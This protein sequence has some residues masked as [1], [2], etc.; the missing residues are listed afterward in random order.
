MT[1]AVGN[2]LTRFEIESL[3]ARRDKI[4]TLFD[5]MIAGRGVGAVL[6]SFTP[7]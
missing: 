6:Y 5:E 7:H 2:S 1:Q 3:L 4:I